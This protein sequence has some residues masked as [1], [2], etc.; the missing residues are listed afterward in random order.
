MKY[1][2]IDGCKI[3]W[4]W[5]GLDREGAYETGV[6]TQ[7]PD[8]VKFLNDAELILVDIPIGLPSKG[9]ESRLCD[10]EARKMI[11][12]RGSSVFPAPARSA[13]RKKTYAEGSQENFRVLGKK[14]SH[15]SWAI[16]PKIKEV[17]DFL[18]TNKPGTTIREMHPEVAF[19]ALNGG[20]PMRHSKKRTAGVNERLALLSQHWAPAKACYEEACAKNLRK[21]VARDNI[22]DGLFVR[23]LAVSRKKHGR[24]RYLIITMPAYD[25]RRNGGRAWI[26]NELSADPE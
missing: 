9:H 3:G 14:L 15:Q 24:S 10:T 13:L 19:C 4:F 20:T 12:P 17:D 6:L 5:V 11:S 21:H 18:R 8:I 16:A 2:G 25:N 22:L 7:F 23:R 26:R 1:I